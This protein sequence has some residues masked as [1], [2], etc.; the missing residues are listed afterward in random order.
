V[1]NISLFEYIES[2]RPE[3][4][5]LLEAGQTIYVVCAGEI[6]KHTVARSYSCGRYC[7]Y[8]LDGGTIWDND[9]NESAF[10]ELEKAEQLAA[11]NKLKYKHI[12]SS[13]MDITDIKSFQ[14]KA[15]RLP[16]TIAIVNKTMVYVKEYYIYDFLYPFETSKEANKFF[17]ETAERLQK[18]N[19]DSETIVAFNP[20]TLYWCNDRYGHVKYFEQNFMCKNHSNPYKDIESEEQ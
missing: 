20:L 1:D 19:P 17:K 2:Q 12:L 8:H 15:E 4:V 5:P 9:I 16:S 7:G 13:N 18:N 10:T 14:S 3:P 6:F 11:E